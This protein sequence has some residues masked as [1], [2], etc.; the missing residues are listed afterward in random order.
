MG[1]VLVLSDGRHTGRNPSDLVPRFAARGIALDFRLFQR[2][3]AQ[4]VAVYRVQ[5]PESVAPKQA[6]MLTAWVRSPVSQEI[7]YELRCGSQVLAAGKKAVS[8]GLS[9]LMFRDRADEPGVRSYMLAVAGSGQDPVPEN[10]AAKLLV[11]VRGRRPVLCVT[12]AGSRSG[13]ARALKEGGVE[14][15]PRPPGECRWAMED[16]AQYA[17]VVVENTL[18]NAIGSE[19][20]ENLAAWVQSAAGGFMMT[21][22]KL[23]YGPG[24][25]FKSPLERILPI[26]ME[27][28]QEHRKLSVAIVIAMDRSGSMQMPAGGGKRKMDLADLGAAEVLDMLSPVDEIGVIAV[29]SQAHV[30]VDMDTVDRN[31]AYRDTILRIDSMGGG[32]F[33]Y[34]ALQAACGMMS[35]AKSGTRH[36]ILFADAADSEEPGAYKQLLE[37]AQQANVTV[38]VVGMGTERDCDAGLL[39]DIAERGGGRIFFSADAAEIPRLFAQDTFAVA[40]STFVEDPASIRLTG[41]LATLTALRFGEP[42]ALGGYNLCYARPDANVAALTLDEYKA[43][44]VA[45]W[46]VGNGRALCYMGEADG[47]FAGPFAKWKDASALLGSLAKWTAGEEANLAG[48]AVVTQQVHEGLYA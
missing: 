31:R 35:K 22:G 32:I 6:F 18:A 39:K 38:S 34:E 8:A 16:L 27:L 24:G 1:R 20:M 26:S 41:G 23:S 21:G 4:D 46:H 37:K 47:E 42:P 11:G 14:V 48:S 33:I 5:A 15:R 10:N 7:A 2:S 25:Y 17:A 19:G 40:R 12:A 43:P 30:I 44:I 9:R 29:D 28:R 13:F 3:S 45:A 36:I